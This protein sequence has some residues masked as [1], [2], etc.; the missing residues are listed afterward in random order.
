MTGRLVWRR[1]RL[2]LALLTALAVGL[3]LAV[4]QS[5][6]PNLREVKPQS[7]VQDPD[8][9][10]DKDGKLKPDSKLWVLNFNFLP[11]RLITVDVPKRGRKVCWY[12]WYQVVNYTKE[13]HEFIPDFELVTQDQGKQELFHDQIMPTIENAIRKIEDPTGYYNIKNSVTITYDPI[14]PSKPDAFPRKTTGVA[15][16]VDDEGKLGNTNSFSIFVTG[17]SNG[18]SEDDNGIRRRKTLQLN[19]KRT[20]DGIRQ[21]SEEIQFEAPPQWIYRASSVSIPKKKD[22]KGDGKP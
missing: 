14:P 10:Y 17:L 4:G 3:P 6:N 13:P 21:K 20:G 19:F 15:I 7:N 5:T 1:P 2:I 8:E 22:D 18:Y 9:L 11:P 16:W 12:L